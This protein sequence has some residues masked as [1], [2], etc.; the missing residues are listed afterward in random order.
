MKAHPTTI[1]GAYLIEPG[2]SEDE[3]GWF[4]TE[5]ENIYAHQLATAF[6]HMERTLRGMHY[7]PVEFPQKKLVRCIAGSILDQIVDLRVGSATYL[8]K[9][10]AIMDSNNRLLMFVPSGVAHGYMTLSPFTEVL[11]IME[12]L[13]KP[14]MERGVRWNDPS[15]KLWWPEEP[16]LMSEK[17][18]N[19]PDFT[20]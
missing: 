9:F 8:K 2:R 15:L 13:Y 20:P 5:F 12:G 19:W 11:Y 10:D 16:I 14:G 18:R 17:D 4:S 1:E 3:R 7:Q 6:N